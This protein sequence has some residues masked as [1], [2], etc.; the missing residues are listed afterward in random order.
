MKV[1]VI[2]STESRNGGFVNTVTVEAVKQSV[3]GKSIV[4]QRYLT[5][6]EEAIISDGDDE[7]DITDNFDMAMFTINVIPSQSVDESTGEAVNRDNS[8]LV[9]KI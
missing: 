2:K 6:T 7:L 4:K 5:K 1:L 8:W 9:A 3:F